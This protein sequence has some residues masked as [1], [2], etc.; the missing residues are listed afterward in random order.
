MNNDELAARQ[1]LVVS[2]I[3]QRVPPAEWIE[4]QDSLPAGAGQADH[5]EAL[6]I[7]LEERRD[8][9]DS[10]E[11]ELQKLGI[12][13][14][15]VPA[16]REAYGHL[17]CLKSHAKAVEIAA[18][19]T[20]PWVVVFEDDFVF[21]DDMAAVR[22][23][24]DFLLTHPRLAPVWLGAWE[25]NGLRPE[26]HPDH[27]NVRVAVGS[28]TTAGCYFVRADYLMVLLTTWQ[29]SIEALIREHAIFSAKKR[30][31]EITSLEANLWPY[32]TDCSWAPIQRRDRWLLLDPPLGYQDR[33]RFGSDIAPTTEFCGA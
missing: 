23:Q 8:R 31:G 16:I 18:R 14:R 21:H 20:S 2:Q 6:Y 22:A 7:N 26:D 32:N 19:L 24:L 28:T 15:R 27:P 17:G 30:N 1:A 5:C 11:S 3:A 13:F 12:K 25:I 33:Q 9:R 29:R 4:V 10:I